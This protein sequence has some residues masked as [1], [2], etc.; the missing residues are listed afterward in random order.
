MS[1]LEQL[2]DPG[3]LL[4]GFLAACVI[5]IVASFIGHLLPVVG[6]PIIAIVL[7]ILLRGVLRNP[8]RTQPGVSFT[9]KRVLQFAIILLGA[10]LN[11]DVVWKTGSQ[12]F[13]VMIGSLAVALTG[14]TLIGKMF[15]LPRNII[16]LITVGTSICGASAISAIAPIVAAE[17]GEIAYAISTIFL[18]NVVAVFL[19]PLIGHMFHFSSMKFGMW[20][21]TAINDTSSVVAAGYSFSHAAG[22]YA[23][24]VKLTR[25]LAIIP[26]SLWFAF[27]TA[28][29]T[30]NQHILETAATVEHSEAGPEHALVD[31]MPRRKTRI[32][33]PMFILGFVAM[34]A[35]DTFGLFGHTVATNISLL[36]EFFVSVALAAIG[37][38]TNLRSLMKTGHRPLLM[39]L[40][41]W[42]L[43]AVSSL[44]L[45]A[46][47]Q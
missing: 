27:M 7:G 6:A 11:L 18:F 22:Q 15:H 2:K 3:R 37:L 10:N 41:T 40:S 31:D 8:V 9:A 44:I 36:G 38:N 12:S 25:S 43:V 32:Q 34:A 13:W 46:I 30:Q 4:P 16:R 29:Q 26:V 33:F 21:G 45:Q 17:E 35:L 1:L 19:F 14:G 47:T 23:T 5:A 24:V 42:A 20:A 39:G 28:K